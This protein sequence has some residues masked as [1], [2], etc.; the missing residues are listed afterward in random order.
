VQRDCYLETGEARL[1][2]NFEAILLPA[3]TRTGQLLSF[4]RVSFERQNCSLIQANQ[5]RNFK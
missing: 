3:V 4:D 5:A 1:E 2:L